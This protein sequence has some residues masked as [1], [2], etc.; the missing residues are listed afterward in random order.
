[1]Y[2]FPRQPGDVFEYELIEQR[3]GFVSVLFEGKGAKKLFQPEAGGHRWQ[4]IPPTEKRG[5]VHTS[6]VTVAVM[7]IVEF[8]SSF[9]EDDVEFQRSRGT[10]PGGQH[11]NVTESCVV[12]IH[13]PTGITVKA[14]MRSQHRSKE[15]ALRVLQE[16]VFE[17]EKQAETSKRSEIRKNQVGSGMRG[18]KIRTYRSQD[19]QVTDHRTGKQWQ[20][21][22]WMKGNW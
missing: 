11:R 7:D 12:A 4:R 10:G 3:S 6:T 5:R 8:S 19:N 18:D 17:L 1:M 9:S 16:R 15:I 14:D 22:K 20:L 21:K 2:M 13:K